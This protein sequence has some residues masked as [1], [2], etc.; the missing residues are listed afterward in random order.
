MRK[1]IMQVLGTVFVL[2]GLLGFF[3]PSQGALNNLFHLTLTHN[4]IHFIT[5][6]LFLGVSNFDKYSQWTARV[7]G[8]IYLAGAILGLFTNNIFNVIMVTPLIEVIHFIVA[9]V[10]LYAGFAKESIST[11]SASS[12]SSTQNL[13]Q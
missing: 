10:T 9:A 11:K 8:V 7:F 4:L 12:P 3:V 1:N 5:G 2:I 6:A 13:D